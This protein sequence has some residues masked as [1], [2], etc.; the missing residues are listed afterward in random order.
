MISSF[1]PKNN[2]WRENIARS[3][4][5]IAAEGLFKFAWVNSK[6]HYAN[7]TTSKMTHIGVGIAD[8]NDGKR[9]WVMQ[10]VA[11]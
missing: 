4:D 10:L 8:A 3:D 9:V 1:V 11:K 6:E 5:F 2:G 7:L